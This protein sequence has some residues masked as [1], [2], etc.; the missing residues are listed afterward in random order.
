[1]TPRNIFAYT[2]VTHPLPQYISVN[3]AG[4]GKVSVSVRGKRFMSESGYLTAYLAEITL[5]PHQWLDL[6]KAGVEH[7]SPAD[8]LD[9]LRD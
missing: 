2:D 7:L 4:D 6:L 9:L 5:D 1:M 3:H 8:K